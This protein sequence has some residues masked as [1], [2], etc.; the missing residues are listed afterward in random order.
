MWL[1]LEPPEQVATVQSSYTGQFLAKQ[2][3]DRQRQHSLLLLAWQADPVADGV[4]GARSA[5]DFPSGDPAA[6]A[7]VVEKDPQ[8][9]YA[10]FNLALAYSATNQDP[11]AI[12]CYRKTLA[13]KPKLYEAE[14]N[15]AILLIQEKKPDEAAALLEDAQSQ[16]PKDFRP[17][18]FLGEAGSCS[19]R[20]STVPKRL[21]KL[22]DRPR[23]EVG[24]V[25]SSEWRAQ[26]L[27]KGD[28]MML[29]RTIARPVSWTRSSAIRSSTAGWRV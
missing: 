5:R 17:A 29:P 22:R 18:Y 21:M 3:Y 27:S 10:Q 20:S 11:K 12:E 23:P 6:V 25:R 28:S 14:L 7:G 26:S 8:D 13:A 16:K 1:Q 4:A 19:R 24:S 9:F 2:S 15:L